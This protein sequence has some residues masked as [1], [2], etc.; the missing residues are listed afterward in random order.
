MIDDTNIQVAVSGWFWLLTKC[1]HLI[2]RLSNF[3]KINLLST[4]FVV[5]SISYNTHKHQDQ[6]NKLKGLKVT[7]NTEILGEQFKI[8]LIKK[9]FWPGTSICGCRECKPHLHVNLK[10]YQVISIYYV[11]L[12]NVW[13]EIRDLRDQR[14]E[15]W[16]RSE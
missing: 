1:F 16:E 2:R 11:K 13:R 7:N 6:N 12:R 8:W 14:S 9:Y 4:I 5:S 3:S 10:I 15:I